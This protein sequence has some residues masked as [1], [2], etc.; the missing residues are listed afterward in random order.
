MSAVAGASR[1]SVSTLRAGGIKIRVARRGEGPALLLITGIGASI[2]MWE[3]FARL[4]TERELIAFDAPG[5]GLS[6]RP[7]VPLRMH[8][9]AR[10]VVELLDQLD[11][12]QVDA[13]GYSFG[14]ALAQELAYHS[15]DRVRRLILCATAQGLIGV[16]PR[17][18]PALLLMTPARYYH[19]V[20]FRMIVPRIAGGRTRRDLAQLDQQAA[21]RLARPPDLVGYALQLYAATGWTSLRWLHRV[22]QPTLIL[23]GDDDPVIPIA[24]ARFMAWRM[25]AARLR[26]VEG[27]GHLFLL[28]QPETVVDEISSFLG[29]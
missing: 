27:G 25:P 12:E 28:D 18:L 9:L 1:W 4:I 13:L 22:E 5:A 20:L 2:D 11:L 16:P 15:P 3:P 10:V 6:G 19:P 8:G 24:N 14:G 21:T 29:S 26:V 23:A 7:R 17:P